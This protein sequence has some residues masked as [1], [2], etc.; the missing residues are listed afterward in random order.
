MLISPH[1]LLLYSASPVKFLQIIEDFWN[2][3][4]WV[5]TP[6]PPSLCMWMDLH[7]V[8]CFVL[9]SA[10][11]VNNRNRFPLEELHKVEDGAAERREIRVEA[12]IEGVLVVWHLMFP[13]GLDMRNSQSVADGLHGV[14]WGAV[15]WPEDGCHPKGQLIAGWRGDRSLSMMRGKKAV[16]QKVLHNSY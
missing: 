4:I 7:I 12:D 6:F 2:C 5:V 8:W 9:T 10:V 11:I 13:A 3:E 15:G 16:C 14:G 1:Y